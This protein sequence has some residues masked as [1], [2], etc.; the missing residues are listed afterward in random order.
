MA[1]KARRIFCEQGGPLNFG[2]Q[3]FAGMHENE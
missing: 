3:P 1:I 2:P